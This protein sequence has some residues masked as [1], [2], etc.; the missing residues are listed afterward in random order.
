[1][2][3]LVDMKLSFQNCRLVKAGLLLGL[4]GGTPNNKF[5]SSEPSNF[6]VNTDYVKCESKGGVNIRSDIHVL[7]VGDP[8]QNNSQ[9][10]VNQSYSDIFE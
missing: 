6:D 5:S 4:V 2:L 1:M 9:I 7:M 10:L 8:G 3:R